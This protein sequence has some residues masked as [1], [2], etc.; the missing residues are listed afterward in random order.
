MTISLTTPLA[1]IKSGRTVTP[2]VLLLNNGSE[3]IT[4]AC[5][6]LTIGT[7]D[8]AY[9]CKVSGIDIKKTK[10]AAVT[11][12]SWTAAVLGDKNVTVTVDDGA[13]PPNVIATWSTTVTVEITDGQFII[14]TFAQNFDTT[15]LPK[16]WTERIQTARRDME[17]E[18]NLA[19]FGIELFSEVHDYV[20][21]D[22]AA[23]FWALQPLHGP[24]QDVTQYGLFWGSMQ[25]G[26]FDISWLSVDTAR[27]MVELIPNALG[28]SGLLFS[29][30]VQGLS[31]VIP[32]FVM[33]N[34]IPC[35]FHIT[36]HAGI[37]F[38]HMTLAQQQSFSYAVARRAFMRSLMFVR[39]RGMSSESI[40]I[41][42]ASQSQSYAMGS[43]YGALLRQLQSE[44]NEW[45]SNISNEYATNITT[46][47]V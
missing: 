30:L 22:F 42:G 14:D 2:A 26:T 9:S 38:D 27:N 34:R 24:I 16:D 36:F 41:D 1:L 39:P 32:G 46:Q 21:Q 31:T 25:I 10:S 40:G 20:L 5:V 43:E 8:G 29:A 3:D 44:D 19:S 12:D 4:G 15:K 11:F 33:Y 6:T 47:I 18:T 28:V 23:T 35:V 13:T 17:R 7:G 37:D 45:I